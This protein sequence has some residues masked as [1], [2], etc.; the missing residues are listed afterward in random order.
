MTVCKVGWVGGLY[1]YFMCMCIA[2]MC[3][4]CVCPTVCVIWW[5]ACVCVCTYACYRTCANM[6]VSL[7]IRRHTSHV[8]M[9]A[10]FCLKNVP[11]GATLPLPEGLGFSVFAL[12]EEEFLQ[13]KGQRKL[14]ADQN[15]TPIS[16]FHPPPCRGGSPGSRSEAGQSQIKKSI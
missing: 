7:K 2:F 14:T 10:R 5:C 13:P 1:V 6:P 12:K 4:C 8:H 11:C 9:R 15:P 3:V 16:L